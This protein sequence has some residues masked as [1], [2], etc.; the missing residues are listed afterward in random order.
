MEIVKMLVLQVEGKIF[1]RLDQ[2]KDLKNSELIVGCNLPGKWIL[3][4]G[5]SRVDDIGRYNMLNKVFEFMVIKSEEL[6]SES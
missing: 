4:W 3:H 5:V 2:G 6:F 1:V